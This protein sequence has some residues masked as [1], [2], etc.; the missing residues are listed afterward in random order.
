MR[1]LGLELSL[2][3]FWT[4]ATCAGPLVLLLVAAAVAGVEGTE[5]TGVAVTG[6]V[7]VICSL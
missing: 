2:L 4:D 1:G 6:G 3:V 5:G 7:I